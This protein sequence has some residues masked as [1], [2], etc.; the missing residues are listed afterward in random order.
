MK[1][2]L[3]QRQH[4]SNIAQSFR[5]NGKSAIITKVLTEIPAAASA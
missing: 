4:A 5:A 1:L 2:S 3:P